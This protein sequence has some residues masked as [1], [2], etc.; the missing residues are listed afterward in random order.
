MHLVSKH[1]NHLGKHR[2]T[3]SR[4]PELYDLGTLALVNASRSGQA[5]C[6]MEPN[7]GERYVTPSQNGILYPGEKDGTKPH[8]SMWINPSLLI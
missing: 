4:C 7:Y 5:Q 1:E 3:V 6:K 2:G 8:V